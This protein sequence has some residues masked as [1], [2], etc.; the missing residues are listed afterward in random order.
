MIEPITATAS[1]ALAVLRQGIELH[2]KSGKKDIRFRVSVRHSVAEGEY[3]LALMRITNQT[4]QSTSVTDLG[5]WFGERRADRLPIRKIKIIDARAE[6]IRV[7][8]DAYIANFE[9][10]DLPDFT[11]LPQDIYLR[12]HETQSGCVL[13]RLPFPT[14]GTPIDLTGGAQTLSPAAGAAAMPVKLEIEVGAGLRITEPIPFGEAE[15]VPPT[16]R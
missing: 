1:L 10:R 9:R 5:L 8:S 4:D 3:A 15:S 12:A 7:D 11:P 13:F 2:E 14:A 16:D 6:M